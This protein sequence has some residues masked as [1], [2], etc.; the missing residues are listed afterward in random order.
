MF[1]AFL[2]PFSPQP[3]YD[4]PATKIFPYR[5]GQ[6]A[7]TFDPT[8]DS[9]NRMVVGYN[10]YIGGNFVGVYSDPTGPSTDPDTY[11]NDFQ[12]W[13]T[14][15]AFDA[16]DNLY[17]GDANR[18]RV[19]VYRKPITR[20]QYSL[21][22]TR[23]GK[24]T[25]TV[26]SSPVGIS[27]GGTCTKAFPTGTSVA[28]S[29]A[30]AASSF[31]AGWSGDADCSGG[32]VTMIWDKACT[33]R[34]DLLPD[35]TV[36]AL[37]AP[38]GAL[39]GST[40]AVTDTTAN[41]IGAGPAAAS[42]TKLYLS[43]NATWDA[44]DTLLGSRPVPGLA[45][46]GTSAG[47]TN[48]TIPPGTPTGTYYIIARAD[49]GGALIESVETNNTRAIVIRVSP[50]DLIVSALSVPTKGGSSLSM[51][52]TST[53]RNQANTGPAAAS[54]TKFYISTNATW[55]AQDTLVGSQDIGPL[56]PG[57]FEVHTTTLQIPAGFGPGTLYVIAKADAAGQI[58][59]TN[60]NNNTLSDTTV[61]GPDLIVSDLVVPST[62]TASSITITD[63]TKNQ[64]G[65]Q[66]A[67]SVTSFYL[68]TNAAW[69]AKDVFLGGIA[70]GPLDPGA[71]FNDQSTLSIPSNT[72]PGT[73][74]ILARAD[75]GSEVAE[76]SETN[77]VTSRVVHINP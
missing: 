13:P 11:L 70:V 12:S 66:A 73:Y 1:D 20:S 44:A 59:E 48:L 71:T 33:A 30:S 42:T 31:F 35:L 43:T 55:D 17:V 15:I 51:D 60:E 5:G 4:V 36:S 54:T 75:A 14:A 28:L 8:F 9:G 63:T 65:G 45:P 53:T 68:S 76:T 22:V 57:A 41:Q 38:A 61:I 2:F 32:A 10:S 23:S 56:A 52:A 39:A 74:Y 67:A 46:G 21:T 47:P 49:A 18:S 34:F 24:G 6:A 62:A 77:N 19:L 25:G 40:I 29:A 37:T 64:G 72:P 27:C 16:D 26:T 69:D 58:P 50:P 7:I 3:S